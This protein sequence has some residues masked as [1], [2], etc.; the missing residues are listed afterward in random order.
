MLAGEPRQMVTP[1]RLQRAGVSPLF[2]GRGRRPPLCETCAIS[3]QRVHAMA[4]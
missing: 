4:L 2:R 1:A 3:A